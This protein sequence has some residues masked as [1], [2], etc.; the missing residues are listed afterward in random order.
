MIPPYMAGGKE[1]IEAMAKAGIKNSWP[2]Y[3]DGLVWDMLGQLGLLL[4]S[5]AARKHPAGLCQAACL[6]DRIFA[7]R[8]LYPHLCGG[9]S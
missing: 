7:I 2:E 6:H 1:V 9:F 5:D 8:D 4:K 3:E